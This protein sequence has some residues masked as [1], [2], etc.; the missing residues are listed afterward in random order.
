MHHF[1]LNLFVTKSKFV[2]NLYYRHTIVFKYL[3]LVHM[4]YAEVIR[5]TNIQI[6]IEMLEESKQIR[7]T[8]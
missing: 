5:R 3:S 8:Y 2:L 6:T 1:W 7:D 4:P